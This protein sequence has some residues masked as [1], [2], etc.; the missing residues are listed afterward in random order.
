MEI[1]QKIQSI[2]ILSKLTKILPQIIK[3]HTNV[4]IYNKIRLFYAEEE[5]KTNRVQNMATFLPRPK[6]Y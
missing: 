6:Y 3:V 4:R 1:Y 5:G 2:I